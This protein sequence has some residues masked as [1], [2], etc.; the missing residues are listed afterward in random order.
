VVTT[1]DKPAGRGLK[2]QYSAVKTFAIE[3]NIPVLQPEKLSDGSFINEITELNPDIIVVVAFRKLPQAIWSIPKLGTF[4][5]HTSLLP[6]YR[7]A[8]PIN[9][10]IING[11]TKT[12]ITTFLLDEQIDTGKILLQKEIAIDAADTFLEVHDKLMELGAKCA[13]ETINM[14]IN[15]DYEAISQSSL[16]ENL[17]TLLP[18]PKIH[19]EDCKIDWNED[20]VKIH[21]KIRGL[22]PIPCA[23]TE[24]ANSKG[25]LLSI[26][27]FRSEYKICATDNNSIGKIISDGKTYLGVNASNGVVY[28][29][30]LQLAGKKRMKVE[31]FLRGTRL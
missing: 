22:S 29:T 26:K 23:F 8:A 25:D 21:N 28:I 6:Q 15:G 9:H 30:D 14:L 13:I 19:K 11:E 20:V 1:P 4:N 17:G 7:G 12:G 10:A 31:E 24:I 27:I 5:I 2:M 16:S 3:N 18:A